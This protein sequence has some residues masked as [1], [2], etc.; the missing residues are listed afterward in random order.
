MGEEKRRSSHKFYKGRYSI[1]F[2]DKD[3]EEFRYGFDNVIEILK[4]RKMPIT[5][6]NVNLINVLLCRALKGSHKIH[7]LVPGE[8]LTVYLIDLDE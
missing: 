3:G 1:A 8:V 6:S 5:R 7:F 4:F 2:Y